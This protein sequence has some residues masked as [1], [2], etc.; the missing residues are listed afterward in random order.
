MFLD[1]PR[2]LR[3][4]DAF[5]LRRRMLA[6]ARVR[7]LKTWADSIAV[8]RG[9]NVPYPDPA[10]GGVDAKVLILLEAPTQRLPDS[11]EQAGFLSVDND[12]AAAEEMWRARELVGLQQGTALH[13]AIVP[14]YL[15]EG[16]G[17]KR[18]ET[19]DGSGLLLELLAMLPRLDTVINC[20]LEAQKAWHEFVAPHAPDLEVIDTWHPATVAMAQEGKRADLQDAFRRA[21]LRTF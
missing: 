1:A 16:T 4:K 7:D 3:D 2:G 9:V 13:W 21:A 5:D 20:G 6:L 8:S 10:D 19:R 17:P 15:P 12:S 14:W 11:A 18:S